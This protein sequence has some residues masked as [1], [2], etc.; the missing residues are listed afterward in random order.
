[1]AILKG[2]QSDD[3]TLKYLLQNVGGGGGGSQADIDALKQIV[4]NTPLTTTAQNLT[5]A[6]NE[7][8]AEIGSTALPTTA[9]TLTGAIAELDT[10]KAEKDASNIT[11]STWLTALGLGSV[12][13]TTTVSSIA[14]AASD[15]TISSATYT[16]WGKIAMVDIGVTK[17]TATNSASDTTICTLVS[18]KRPSSAAPSVSVNTNVN[19]SFIGTNGNVHVHRQ[20]SANQTCRVVAIYILA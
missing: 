8:D 18:G 11:A 10:D 20:W 17:T 4:G 3:L 13:S 1:M 5:D 15:F 6:V 12:T 2:N 9:Q 19:Y 14:S 16:Q 7:L